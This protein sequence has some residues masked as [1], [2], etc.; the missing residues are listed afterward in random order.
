[1]TSPDPKTFLNMLPL[2]S[3]TGSPA[4]IFDNDA[5]LAVRMA[6]ITRRPLLVVGEAGCGKT[7]SHGDRHEIAG[8]SLRD[9]DHGQNAC[10]WHAD[11]RLAGFL[12]AARDRRA[13]S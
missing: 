10:Q 9:T 5:R 1:M 13:C 7:V 12:R 11:H 2:G 6:W 3:G 8:C 4:Y